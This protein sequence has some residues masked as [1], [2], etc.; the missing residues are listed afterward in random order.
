MRSAPRRPPGQPRPD[1][2]GLLTPASSSKLRPVHLR[3]TSRTFS[4]HSR[5]ASSGQQP[6][7]CSHAAA[8][9]PLARPSSA[10]R[11]PLL[12]LLGRGLSAAWARPRGGRRPQQANSTEDFLDPATKEE[13][14]GTL[15]DRRARGGGTDAQGGKISQTASP[16]GSERGGPPG[17]MWEVAA[18]HARAAG[19]QSRVM[20]T[21][22]RRRRDRAAGRAPPALAPAGPR[23][24]PAA[25]HA[26]AAR[27]G[28]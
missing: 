16:R 23:S 20:P 18:P 17:Q 3:H 10:P 24:W 4:A 26:R 13:S 28:Q 25:Q 7:R 21:R 11:A 19:A 5:G 6:G 14:R 12:R 15:S 9:A 1:A 2:S 27:D 22:F 8:R